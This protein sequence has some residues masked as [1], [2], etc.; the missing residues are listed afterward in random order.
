MTLQQ[1]PGL[2]NRMLEKLL[3]VRRGIDAVDSCKQLAQV[4]GPTCD[5]ETEKKPKQKENNFSL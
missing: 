3:P 2:Q 5:Q 4:V 1:N